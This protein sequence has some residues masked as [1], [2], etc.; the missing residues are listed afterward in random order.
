MTIEPYATGAKRFYELGLSP[1]PL[2]GKLP[3]IKWRAFQ[4]KKMSPRLLDALICKHGDKNIG[5]IT[6]AFTNLTIVDV[7]ANADLQWAIDRFGTPKLMCKSPREGGGFHLYYR[8]NGERNR[9]KVDGR[10]VDVRGQ[11]GLV[12]LPDSRTDIGS[13]KLIEGKWDELS[14]LTAIAAKESEL[15][16][17]LDA[18]ATCPE[19]GNRNKLLFDRLRHKAMEVDSV[20]ALTTAAVG[21]NALL[22]QPLSTDEVLRTVSSV[23]S[24]RQRGSLIVTGAGQKL[25][26]DAADLSLSPDALWLLTKLRATH[27]NKHT[28]SLSVRA[29]APSLGWTEIRLRKA[30]DELVD[31]GYLELI[32]RGGRSRSGNTNP[33]IYRLCN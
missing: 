4:S 16:S 17:L 3:A 26:I 15:S 2:N 24:Y 5:T 11:G 14:N 22:Q 13:Y 1:I 12:V 25:F 30:R 27:W 6:G 29:M 19:V 31:R 28:F 32:S 21:W 33:S 8:Y 20:E 18:A 10:A 9:T 7:D 23:W